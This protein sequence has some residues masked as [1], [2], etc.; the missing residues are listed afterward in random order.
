MM[1]TKTRGKSRKKDMTPL[2]AKLAAQLGRFRKLVELAAATG[3]RD[4]KAGLTHD[5]TL[6][7]YTRVE[8]TPA[9]FWRV[10]RGKKSLEDARRKRR[11]LV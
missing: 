11:Q 2:K 6:S 5:E 9:D 4:F 8:V 10:V 7:L 3:M 1:A